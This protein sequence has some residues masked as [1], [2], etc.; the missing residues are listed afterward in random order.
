MGKNKVKL[1]QFFTRKNLWLKPQIK[2]FIK[3]SNCSIAYDPFAG[4][5]D[6]LFCSQDYVISDTK[7][8][9]IDDKLNWELNDSLKNIPHMDDA[10][11]ITNPPY[12]TNYS[13]KRKK[14]YSGLGR[15]F[16]KYTDLYQLAIVK[17]LKAQDYIVAIIP[18]TFINSSFLNEVHKRIKS[19]TILVNNPFEDTEN[20]VCVV[21]FDNNALEDRDTDVYIEDEYINSLKYIK[22]KMMEPL[23][24]YKIDFNNVNGKLAIRAVDMPS[25]DK[26]I[27]FMSVDDLSYDLNNIKNSSRLIT[28]VDIENLDIDIN[29][30]A[31]KCNSI[32][33]KYRE[34]TRDINLSPFK[35]NA[36]DGTR[37]RRL[38]YKTARAI[39][40]IAIDLILNEN[41]MEVDI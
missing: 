19:I 32:L 21:C 26:K 16:K 41:V 25:V 31:D 9:D 11:I 29:L 27:K 38:D 36:K 24:K 12:L 28:V 8:L 1:G 15:Y 22:S 10:I 3:D 35:G 39:I 34:E 14:I 7:G 6:L 37:R 33:A 2:Q 13:A 18:E 40:E 4:A 20:P 30:L 5:G 17:M 23:R